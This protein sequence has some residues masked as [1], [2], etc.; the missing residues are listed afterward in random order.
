MGVAPSQI[1]HE[2]N[3]AVHV[4]DY[5]GDPRRRPLT[6]EELQAFFDAADDH[7]DVVVSNARKGA[8]AVF[9]DATLFKVIYAWGL[10]QKL[11]WGPSPPAQEKKR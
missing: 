1:C 2:W 6:R 3:S 10:R 8:L 5:E 11:G 9:R 7:V 4:A